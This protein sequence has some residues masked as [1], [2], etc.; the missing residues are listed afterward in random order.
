MSLKHDIKLATKMVRLGQKL[1]HSTQDP[2]LKKLCLE[3]V[4][5][6]D[7]V[8]RKLNQYKSQG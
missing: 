7:R 1:Q 3:G 2:E 4:F 5:Y 6:F 8:L